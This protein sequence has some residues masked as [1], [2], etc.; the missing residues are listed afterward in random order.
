[1][2]GP[3]FDAIVVGAGLVGTATAYELGRAGAR[4][5][6]VDRNDP[7]RA[8]DAGAGILSPETA[9]RDDAAWTALVRAAGRHYDALLPHLPGDTGWARCGILELATRDTDVAAWEWVAER[10]GGAREISSD[11]ARGMLP[12]LAPM[13]RALYHPAAARVDGRLLCASM[14][15]AAQARGVE[16]RTASIDDVQD[17]DAASTVVIAGG[18][19]TPGL[20]RKFGVRLPVGPVR[21][22]IMHLDVPEHDTSSWPIAQPVYGHYM[23]PW[24][25]RRVAVGATVEDAGF[26]AAVTAGGVQEILR[27]ALRVMPGLTSAHLRDVRVGLRPWSEDDLPI[28]GRLAAHPRVIVATGH[29][30]HGL[31]L[32]PVTGKLVA[33]LV[34]D[35]EPELDL[36]PFSP[37]RFGA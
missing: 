21:G 33:D 6:L 7:G 37:A 24:A 1:M 4:T 25:D 11:E 29:G 20:A 15:A 2:S 28:V 14:R 16:V 13:L 17:V 12:V 35:R 26:E 8:T 19:W 34:A 9:K 5:L 31:L 32:G 22:Q 36:V 30:A 27:E 10:A 18:A 23:V 3:R